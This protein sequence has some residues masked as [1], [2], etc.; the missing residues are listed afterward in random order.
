LKEHGMEQFYVSLISESDK[1]AL[2]YDITSL[3]SKSKMLDWLDYGY[4]RDGL[5]LPQVNL[6]LVMSLKRKYPFITNSFQE[7]LAMWLP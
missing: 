3:S 1:D 4:N 7:A 2:A 6:G 5:N